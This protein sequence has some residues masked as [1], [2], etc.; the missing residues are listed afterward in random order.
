MKKIILLGAGT[1][2]LICA[3]AQENNFG[4]SFNH[5][6]LSVKDANIAATFYKDALGL[7]EIENRTK[8]EGRRWLSLGQ[9]GNEL[10]LVSDLKNEK[11]LINKAIHLALTTAN[12]EGFV[13]KLTKLKIAFSDWP[14]TPSKVSLRADGV[15]QI[16]FQDADGYWIEVNSVAQK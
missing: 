9:D 7:K 5:L 14:G 4:F 12:F 1:F 11:V 13:A 3:Q 8:V 10:H 15:K 6:A 16:F 2:F